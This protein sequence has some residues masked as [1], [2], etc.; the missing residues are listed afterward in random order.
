MTLPF[1]LPNIGLTSPLFTSAGSSSNRISTGS[2]TVSDESARPLTPPRTLGTG[3]K[4]E[5]PH[6]IPDFDFES[7][8]GK[9]FDMDTA[10]ESEATPTEDFGPALAPLQTKSSIDPLRIVKRSSQFG[11]DQTS[12]ASKTAGLPGSRSDD[13]LGTA[14]GGSL[15]GQVRQR[16]SKDMIR[17]RMEERKASKPSESES[18]SESD[19]DLPLN[20]AP[21]RTALS[22]KALPARPTPEETQPRP[23]LRART[24]TRSAQ[25]IL[26]Q[27]GTDGLPE[28]PKSALDQLVLDFNGINVLAK[29]ERPQ[30]L[31]VRHVSSESIL[32]TGP[33][34]S[35]L[36]TVTSSTLQPICEMSSIDM[37]LE[38]DT[39]LAVPSDPSARPRRRRSMSTGDARPQHDRVSRLRIS[40]HDFLRLISLQTQNANS[41]M[42][43]LSTLDDL[44]FKD[45]HSMLAAF[46]KDVQ[47]ITADV[48][49]RACCFTR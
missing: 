42:S 29:P 44:D 31:V 32:T 13:S 24:Q 37:S 28:E 6:R 8:G 21:V 38:A 47:H 7:H 4:A 35:G 19:E 3:Q 39:I 41:R 22:E 2:D 26:A 30:S 25:D 16:I 5:S 43:I 33:A 46:E 34:R 40:R 15:N 36:P 18:G 17:A 49:S 45:N 27:A 10:M 20:I 23:Q 14:N 12:I 48:R 9:S 11:L 1:A